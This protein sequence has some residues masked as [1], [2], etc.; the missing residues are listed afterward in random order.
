[1]DITELGFLHV[2]R[3]NTLASV[4]WSLESVGN[5]INELNSNEGKVKSGEKFSQQEKTNL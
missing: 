2:T 3:K 5:E 1:M 4:K